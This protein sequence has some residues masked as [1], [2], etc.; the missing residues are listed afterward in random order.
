MAHALSPM[1]ACLATASSRAVIALSLGALALGGLSLGALGGAPPAEE[2]VDFPTI[3]ARTRLGLGAVG[4]LN[5]AQ[6]PALELL[7]S[8]FFIDNQGHFLTANHVLQAMEEKKRLGDLRVFLP[9]DAGPDGHPASVVAR[10][11]RHDFALLKV[12]GGSYFPLELGDSTKA[13][14]GQSIALAGFPF[15]FFLGLH[16]STCVGII[17]S[18]SPAAVPVASSKLLDADTI[19]ALR[20]PYKVFQL[21]ATAH[22]GHSGGPLF[23][24]RTGKVLGIVNSA[25]IRKTKEKVISSGISYAMPIHLARPMLEEA[26][27]P[28]LGTPRPSP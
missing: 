21:D 6:R 27:K 23:D 16:P 12:K 22:P 20:S 24:P 19:E 18:I 15:G 4:V 3:V 11:P 14:E 1:R 17:S 26:L 10:D 13:R 2:G 28:R 9:S 7:G 8:G 25:F 5:P